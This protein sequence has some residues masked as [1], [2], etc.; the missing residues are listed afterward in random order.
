MLDS[1]AAHPPR[2][3]DGQADRLESWKSIANYLG[4]TVRTVRRWEGSEGLPIHRHQHRDRSTVYAYAC[5]L[6]AWLARRERP[7]GGAPGQRQESLPGRANWLRPV[8]AIALPVC[9]LLTVV[10]LGR[11]GDGAGGPLAGHS[12]TAAPAASP[13][14][15]EVLYQE[16]RNHLDRLQGATRARVALEEAVRLA[17]ADA[18][19]HA[20]LGEAYAR[21]ALRAPRPGLWPLA[22]VEIRQALAI[23]DRMARGH[24]ALGYLRAYRDWD[25]TGARAAFERALALDPGD[26]HVRSGLASVL[27]VSGRITEAIVE[28][29][30]ACERLPLQPELWSQLGMDLVFA[31]QYGEAAAAFQRAL[32]LS[33][34]FV[35]AIDGLAGAL[36]LAGREDESAAVRSRA[37]AMAARPEDA[38]AYEDEWRRNGYR[39]AAHWLDRLDLQRLDAAGE[40]SSAWER[41]WR[42]ARLGDVDRA[43]AAIETAL[44]RREPGVLQIGLDPDLDGIRHDPRLQRILDRRDALVH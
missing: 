23:D 22:D 34:G 12:T 43:V 3:Q 19:I 2:D 15:S 31:R 24:A 5:E 18:R 14:K 41:A 40:S 13:P 26:A 39:A 7:G 20:A 9:I 44:D 27:R 17:P 21:L 10:L 33:P 16:G 29:R 38:V 25:L 6:D 36:E 35:M 1:P 11:Y 28:R 4:R 32:R 42:L 30:R 37:L 8:L